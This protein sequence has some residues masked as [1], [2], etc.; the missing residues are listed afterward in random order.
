MAEYD[1]RLSLAA[2]LKALMRSL[3]P[4]HEEKEAICSM[5]LEVLVLEVVPGH[6]Y[7]MAKGK[8]TR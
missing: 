1:D 4:R 7:T 6:K 8:Y 5:L 2:Y 3:V